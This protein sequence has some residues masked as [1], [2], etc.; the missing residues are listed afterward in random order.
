[1]SSAPRTSSAAA[2]RRNSE[3]SPAS[4]RS[5]LEWGAELGVIARAPPFNPSRAVESSKD[6]HVSGKG[7]AASSGHDN[8]TDVTDG[9]HN[10]QWHLDR[11][12]RPGRRDAWRLAA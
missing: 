8:R 6:P 9:S 2:L 4:G 7:A 3:S 12:G 10:D 1:M 11:P 5:S